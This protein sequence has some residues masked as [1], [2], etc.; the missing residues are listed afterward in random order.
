MGQDIVHGS[1]G[2]YHTIYIYSTCIY[3]YI[4][5]VAT[6][7]DAMTGFQVFVVVALSIKILIFIIFIYIQIKN[8]YVY[9]AL[10][11]LD[12]PMEVFEPV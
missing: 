1:Y 7:H 12:P 5:T 3:I 2:V 6:N 9:F 8:M 10:R 11:I 4:H